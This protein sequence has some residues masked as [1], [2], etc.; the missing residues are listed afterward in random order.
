[1]YQFRIQQIVL[2][3]MITSVLAL[4]QSCASSTA[5]LAVSNVPLENKQYEVLGPAESSRG[6][7][8]FDIGILG[9]PLK[10]PPIDEVVSDLLQEKGG[11]ALINLRY[12][13]EKWILLGF[14]YNRF[15]LRADV[16]KMAA[17]DV[18][19]KKR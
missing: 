14:T 4:T 2:L 13:T 17:P 8:I 9:F 11:D 10:S 16:V 12:Y 6:W 3:F 5:G 1:M 15:F 18:N 7:I 19:P